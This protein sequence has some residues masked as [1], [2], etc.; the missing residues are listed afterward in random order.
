VTFWARHEFITTVE[1][2]TPDQSARSLVTILTTLTHRPCPLRRGASTDEIDICCGKRK[3]C[4]VHPVCKRQD[5]LMSQRVVMVV[6]AE[7]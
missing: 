6:T 2:R 5:F 4:K 7:V 1:I 3:K